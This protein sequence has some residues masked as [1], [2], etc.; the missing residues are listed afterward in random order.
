VAVDEIDGQLLGQP[1]HGRPEAEAPQP[2]HAHERAEVAHVVRNEPVQLAGPVG[3]P[4]GKDVYLVA[5]LA[6]PPGPAEEDDR[7]AVAHAQDP[8]GGRI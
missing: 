1:P 7:P 6:E 3:D 5:A 2:L 8:H 4:V